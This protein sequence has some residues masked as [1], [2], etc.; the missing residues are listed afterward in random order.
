M[1]MVSGV[2]QS[3]VERLAKEEVGFVPGA[4]H[5]LT[6]SEAETV[7]S[8][9]GVSSTLH[10]YPD[11]ISWQDFPDLAIVSVWGPSGGRHAVVYIYSDAGA[12]IFDSNKSRPSSVDNYD[13]CDD[14]AY[15]EIH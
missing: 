15:L 13:F 9:L 12:I 8:E 2:S 10:C 5:G 6:F 11:S 3:R 7:L 14:D 4:R 1:A